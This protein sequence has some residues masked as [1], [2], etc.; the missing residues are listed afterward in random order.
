MSL[1]QAPMD[2]QQQPMQQSQMNFEQQQ[3]N[4]SFEQ[5]QMNGS[6]DHES[7]EHPRSGFNSSGLSIG[8]L[9]VSIGNK[10]HT[11]QSVSSSSGIESNRGSSSGIAYKQTPKR[12]PPD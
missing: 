1:S 10:A 4:G 8:D 12:P 9:N 7:T 6:F 11:S 3:M 5:Q 2:F